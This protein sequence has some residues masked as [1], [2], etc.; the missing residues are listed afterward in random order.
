ML[1]HISSEWVGI[2]RAKSHTKLTRSPGWYVFKDNSSPFV[3][4]GE[5]YMTIS[6]KFIKALTVLVVAITILVVVIA[7]V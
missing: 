7:K 4:R 3:Q 5:D 6:T 2:G 1:P